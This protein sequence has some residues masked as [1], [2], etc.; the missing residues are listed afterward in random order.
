MK[1]CEGELHEGWQNPDGFWGNVTMKCGHSNT[2]YLRRAMYMV[3]HK[4]TGN[5]KEKFY[6]P[7][8][9]TLE[10]SVNEIEIESDIQIPISNSFSILEDELCQASDIECDLQSEENVIWTN[11]VIGSIIPVDERTFLSSRAK[12]GRRNRRAKSFNEAVRGSKPKFNLDEFPELENEE[13]TS[14]GMSDY[15]NQSSSKGKPK[16]DGMTEENGSTYVPPKCKQ[17]MPIRIDERNP[18]ITIDTGKRKNESL[19][20]VRARTTKRTRRIPRKYTPNSTKNSV[21]CLCQIEDSGWYIVCSFQYA[22][23]LIYYHPKCVG[24][25]HLHSRDNGARYSNCDDGKSYMCPVCD[26]KKNTVGRPMHIATPLTQ[27]GNLS[28]GRRQEGSYENYRS[29]CSSSC[30]TKASEDKDEGGLSEKE[31]ITSNQS[32]T[33]SAQPSTFKHLEDHCENTQQPSHGTD[34]GS[35]GDASDDD[36]LMTQIHVFPPKRKQRSQAVLKE[37]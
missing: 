14:D 6:N 15:I 7:V 13:D 10:K 8:T 5:I 24:L 4:N 28:E 37:M 20:P 35:V 17:E 32:N 18:T 21:Y 9:S 36:A 22:G 30:S 29:S 11:N 16:R 23:C 26:K 1:A 3:W 31:S 19:L 33:N 12:L 34:I 25:G 2:D 27:N